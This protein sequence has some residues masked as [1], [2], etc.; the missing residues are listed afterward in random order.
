MTTINNAIP[1]VPE[2]TID[3]AAGLNISLNTIDALL[4]VLVQTVGANTPPAGVE[5]QRFI[6]GTSPTGAWAGQANK[7]ARFL[8]GVWT[9]YNARYAV[10]AAD[11][12]WYVRSGATWAS[13]AGGTFTGGTL[14]SALNEAPIVTLASASTVNIGAA[15]A[16]TI[17]IS[18]TTTITALGTIASGAVRQIV[19]QGVLTLTHNGTSLIL[20]TAANITTAAGDIAEF[21]SLG[22]GNWRCTGYTRA[23]GLALAGG[24]GGSAFSPVITES[25]TARTLA[26][27][28]AG[29][30]IR[31]TSASASACTIPPQ[32]SVAWPADAEVYIYRDVAGNLTLT[33]GSGVTLKNPSGGTLVLTNA[34]GVGLKRIAENVWLVIGQTVPA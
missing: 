30:F 4:Q 23:S 28:D 29:A 3:P 9:F 7:L 8:N 12:L 13:L 34:M 15:S 25:T 2:G 24:G 32:A 17:S 27:T 33:A 21:V 16:N 18:G 31:F 1:F 6:V 19:F 20:P 5:G 26:L 14:T 22:S 10:N 11:G